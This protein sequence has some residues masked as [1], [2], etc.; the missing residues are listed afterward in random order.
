MERMDYQLISESYQDLHTKILIEDLYREGKS[1]Q[2]IINVLTEAGL[3]DRLKARWSAFNPFD[4]Q[5][6]ENLKKA[7]S[8]KIGELAQKGLKKAGELAG[9]DP[10]AITQ[11]KAYDK[12]E[13]AELISGREGESGMRSAKLKSILKSHRSDIKQIIQ[14]TIDVKKETEE[15][16]KTLFDQIKT[17]LKKLGVGLPKTS[18]LDSMLDDLSS[19]LPDSIGT[20][21]TDSDSAADYVM[22]KITEYFNKMKT[23]KGK[24]LQKPNKLDYKKLG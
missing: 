19:N 24:G 8:G 1:E 16:F 22:Q 12:A 20:S 17:D 15:Q 11:S 6:R 14:K 5:N 7:A 21:Y 3:M 13:T 2:E 10:D 4:K 18:S 9:I 23:G